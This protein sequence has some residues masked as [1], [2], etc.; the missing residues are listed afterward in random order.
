MSCR[1]VQEDVA[2]ALVTHGDLTA[3]E[4]E[5]VS[6][7]PVCAAEQA[8][9]RQVMAV[10]ALASSVDV[11]PVDPIQASDLLL[12]RILMATEVERARE[13]RHT[14]RVRAL[15]VAAAVV[16][17]VAGITVG[18]SILAPDSHVITASASA[19]GI[20]GTAD[21][22]P[23]VGGSEVRI[24]VTGLPDDTDCIVQVR[25]ADGRTQDIAE[26]RIEYEGV[27]RAVGHATATPETITNVTLTRPDGSVL[28]DIPVVA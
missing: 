28:L 21:I 2:V 7:C 5:H 6:T 24:S 12:Q 17:A 20:Q 14:M 10:M 27:G 16:L 15:A 3:D 25:S 1:Q 26:W 11:R 18:R 9:L 8:S 22:A 4:S 23:T 13:R 19:A